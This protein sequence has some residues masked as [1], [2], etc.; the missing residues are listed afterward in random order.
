MN[1]AAAMTRSARPRGETHRVPAAPVKPRDIIGNHE[2]R[3]L[4]GRKLAGENRGSQ[5]ITRHTLIRLREKE[6]FPEPIRVLK[7][8]PRTD[9]WDRQAVLRWLRDTGRA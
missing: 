6:G 5:P 4:I 8:T 3:A 2:V 7:G 9:L 1:G